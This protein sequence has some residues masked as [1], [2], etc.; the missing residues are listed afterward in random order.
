MKKIDLYFSDEVEDKILNKH[1]ISV[2]EIR[3]EFALGTPKV[4]RVRGNIY[5]AILHH[6]D[7]IT[8]FFEKKNGKGHVLTAYRSSPEQKK[9]Y[10]Q[11]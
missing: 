4:M 3:R 11:K 7:F 10:Y 6:F 5:M 2:R 8:V 1:N 9:R